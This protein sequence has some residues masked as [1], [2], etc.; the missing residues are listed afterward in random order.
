M[1]EVEK[2]KFLA[3]LLKHVEKAVQKN[4]SESVHHLDSTPGP[5][6][7]RGPIGEQGPMGVPGRDGRDGD[8]GPKGDPGTPGLQGP[9]GPAGGPRGQEGEKGET[10]SQGPRGFTGP[11]G[12]SG[13]IGPRGLLGEQGEMGPQGPQGA[14]GATGEQG[15]QGEQGEQGIQGV[16]G[17]QGP[18]GVK[19]D[20]GE[21]GEK[22]DRGE[23]GVPGLR[24]EKGNPGPEGP[25]GAKGQD[26]QTPSIDPL[27]KDIEKFKADIRRAATMGGGSSGGGEVRLEFLDDVDRDSVKQNNRYLKY[28]AA[29]GKFVGATIS[30]DGGSTDQYLEV[31][32][33]AVYLEVANA[34][35]YLE[36]ANLTNISSHIVPSANV[37][38]DLGTSEKRW[39]DLY[40]SGSSIELGDAII[41]A[42]A[43]GAINLPA[44]STIASEAIARGNGGSGSGLNESQVDARVVVGTNKF[45][46]VANVQSLAALANTNAFITTVDNQRGLDLANTNAR[47]SALSGGTGTD[48]L[49]RAGI[50]ATNTAIRTLVSD[51]MQVA[52]VN[53][54]VATSAIQDKAA[55][56]NTNASIAT[57]LA[58]S[59]YT[60]GD[61]QDKA[62]LANT[63]AFITSVD[64]QRNADLANTNAR[65]NTLSGG[66]SADGV[67]R[68]GIVATNT[69]IRILVDDRM[70]VANVNTL[71]NDRLQVANAAIYAEVANVQSLAALANTNSAIASK[72]DSSSYTTADV[73]TK[74]ALANTNAAI[75]TKLASSSYTTGDVQDKAA[76][77]NTNAAI[78]TKLASSSYTTGDVQTKAALANTNAYI[79]SVDTA[80]NNNLA[81]TNAYIG[82]VNTRI[83]T[84]ITNIINAAPESL[85]TLNELASA[86]GDNPNFAT[87][88]TTN[89][90][91]KLG[92]T[93]TVT[94]T[95]DI[96]ASA[97]AFSGNAV[98]LSTVDTNLANT[99][100]YIASVDTTRNANLANTNAQIATKLNSSSYTTADVQTKAAL[101]NTNAFIATKLDSS[102]YTT[103]D[104]QTKAALANTNAAIATKLDSSSY[105]TGDVQT[106][107]A[108]AN[109]NAAIATKLDSSSYTTA[110]VQDKAALANTNAYITSVDAAR[111]NNLANTN[112]YI[113]TKLDS[114]SYTTADVQTKAAL[115]NTNAYIA[116]VDNTR[117]AN[118]ANTNAQIA[119]KLDSSSYTIGDVQTKA[120][121]ANTNAFIA[122]KL[123]DSAA[124]TFGKSLIDDANASTARS[125]LG[126]G[127][128]ATTA[129]SDYATAA[130][131]TKADN[132]LPASS[133]TTA[134][135]QTKAALAN[136]NAYIAS[137]DSTRN[138]N[139]ANTNAFIAT[140]LN[141]SAASTFG[142][143]LIDDANAGV[144]RTTLGLGT[145][146]TTASSDYA[147]AA[148]GTKAD[149]ALPASSY[150]T[151]DVQT[152]AAL[153]NTNSY[154][155]SNLANTNAFIATKL[156]DSAAS[157][158]GKSLIDDANAST[159]RS[160]LGLG[161]A[162]TSATGDFATAAQGALADSALQ[163]ETVTSI[164]LNSNS[165]DY[166]DENGT[167]TNID[168]SAYL[169][170]DSR[171]IASGTLNSVSGVVTFTRD[172]A[173]TFTLDLS[174]L[175]DDTN[176]VTSVAGKNGVV[177][178]DADDIDDTSTTNKFTTAAEITKL[179]GIETGATADQT[180]AEIKTAYESNADTNAFTDAEQSKLSGIETGADVTDTTNV[181]A[182]LTAG[183]NVTIGADGTIS[184][185]D[186][187]TT[188]SVG[189]GGLTQKNF[190]TALN[191]KL[192]GIETGATADQTA[193]EILTAIKTVDGSS[194]GLD[195]DLLDGNHAS[196]FATA[197][198]GTKA[199][200]ALPKTGG[201]MT[202]AITTNST[203]DGRDVATDGTKLDGIEPGATADQTAAEIRTLV[204]SASDSNVFTDADHTKLNGIEASATNTADPAITSD[205]STPSLAAGIT[206]AEVRSLIGAGTS[207][208][209]N[210]T[211]TGEV[212]GAT[213]LTVASNVID[214][215]NLKVTGNGTTSQFLRSD[216]D[217]TFTW[218][219]PTDTNTEYSVGDGGLT[220][221]DFTDADHTKL[222]GIETG[223]TA[224]QTA[225]EILTA[226]KTVDGVA[227][228]LDADLLDGNH[229]SA[230]A[231]AA[232]G[233]KADNA[234]PASSYTTG[235]VQTKAA[236]ANTNSA[237]ASKVNTSS[238]STF[239]FSLVDDAN[240]GAARTTLGLGT[241]ATTASSDYATAAQGSLAD[242]ATQPGDLA[243]VATSGNYSDLNNVL[244]VYNAA[245]TKIFPS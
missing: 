123:N 25:V 26:G 6:G 192:S 171:A 162:A 176:L 67:A 105:T 185:T 90:G 199:D 159:A 112:T 220:T 66:S 61:V 59:S 196:A 234:L 233:T 179:S 48:G 164:A 54:L 36:V 52:N 212:T 169:D 89:I 224:D 227:S 146:A 148:Q 141:D 51:R 244:E 14:I 136:T 194:S 79:A 236:L 151:G 122:T 206:G 120:A 124:S 114:S 204:E 180:A 16:Q 72:L 232:Q 49:A 207:S 39:R 195:A 102:S 53:T 125:T 107:A 94:L 216:G 240:A 143:S 156:D 178:L 226:I 167:T 217:G 97:T 40:L 177:T 73:Q 186:T 99:N 203:F 60:T 211:H 149:D 93:A 210:A 43:N 113:A 12:S 58:S 132:A 242:S 237:I 103:A 45:A 197:A 86:L 144:A 38:Y 8:R 157:T 188:Y 172:D 64:N 37:T 18:E 47:I 200:A 201:A 27:I 96:T 189:D 111:N 33:A 209:D 31:A 101:G 184:S 41:T 11:K 243:T 174:D 170:E 127:T 10:G 154:I 9:Q 138:A 135:V 85:N 245:G 198:Q 22:G 223:A 187:N 173:T 121:L 87:T 77:A 221:N 218:A 115:A 241:A 21:R 193:S 119:S 129:S 166:T 20:K 128:A 30:G 13:P 126:L 92:K 17:E 155:N 145:A 70:Q 205:G 42:H 19:G 3:A 214:A 153:A 104:V 140:K 116:S 133:Y 108:L 142:K 152:K 165:L 74:A 225:A 130:Q 208:S 56:A 150:T 84:E 182:A 183:T 71:V 44:G 160:T 35:I 137:V 5:Q 55:L 78:A 215:D 163:S 168:L 175:L 24:G 32:N 202:G 4:V 106:K 91:Q 2:A 191:T 88:V 100:A 83:D 69:A 239:G 190:T 7:D 213:S 110:D 131:G 34:G 181:V 118:L 57:K 80:R 28:N 235:D 15:P 147:T 229:A 98:S 76:L 228:G 65:I 231:T 219:T 238:L 161:T 109:T 46:E 82:T 81:N 1:N 117:N 50:V 23:P 29:T 95:G 139:L 75:A 63:N 222:N 158:F 134:D 62:A 230:F 68:A